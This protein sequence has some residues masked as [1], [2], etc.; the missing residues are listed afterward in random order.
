MLAEGA[1]EFLNLF[2]HCHKLPGSFN[3]QLLTFLQGSSNANLE[4][5]L[6]ANA[7]DGIYDTPNAMVVQG[8]NG[9]GLDCFI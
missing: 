7:S 9:Y 5:R 4:D 3:T 1:V 6:N 2:H 8:S